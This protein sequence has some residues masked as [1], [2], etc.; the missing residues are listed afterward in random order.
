MTDLASLAAIGERGALALL[1]DSTNVERPGYTMSERKV[2]DT[3]NEQIASAPGRVII[4]MFASNVNR[5]QQVADC[6]I[7]FGRKVCF[8]GRSMINVSTLAMELGYLVIPREHVLEIEDL[9]RYRDD[10]ILVITTGSQGEP[11]SG[12]TRMAFAEHRRLHIK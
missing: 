8:I 10:Q 1:A 3:F 5:V 2:A 12:L 6:A 7:G 4:A 9:D 11:M